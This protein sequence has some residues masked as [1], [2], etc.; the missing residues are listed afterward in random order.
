MDGNSDPERVW[1]RENPLKVM[2][3]LEGGFGG[4]ELSSLLGPSHNVESVSVSHYYP[5]SES[6]HKHVGCLH[7]DLGM[8]FEGFEGKVTVGPELPDKTSECQGKMASEG[9]LDPDPLFCLENLPNILFP[10]Q[11]QFLWFF[12][13]FAGKSAKWSTLFHSKINLQVFFLFHGKLLSVST[14]VSPSHFHKICFPL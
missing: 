8:L 14:D 4:W 12:Y 3:V 9:A 2:C 6:V 5:W 13:C 7:V 1:L 10:E 11:T